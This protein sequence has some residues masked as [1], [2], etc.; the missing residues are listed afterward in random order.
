MVLRFQL[1]KLGEGRCI[2]CLLFRLTFLNSMR[3]ILKYST[4][5][6]GNLLGIGLLLF[7][8]LP[9]HFIT[10]G[11]LKNNRGIKE[12]LWF[13]FVVC[14]FFFFL[15]FARLELLVELYLNFFILF[16]FKV[17]LLHGTYTVFF[18]CYPWRCSNSK[19]VLIASKKQNKTKIFLCLGTK[20]VHKIKN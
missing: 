18:P 7:L 2:C 20:Q 9:F 6:V 11:N 13:C 15:L 16:F 10:L 4:A 1:A 12:L 3:R 17:I 8:A 19:R 5:V 14:F